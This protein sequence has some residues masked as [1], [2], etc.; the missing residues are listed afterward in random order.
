LAKALDNTS[1]PTAAVKAVRQLKLKRLERTLTEAR[2]IASRR[3][4]TRGLKA[5][6]EVVSLEE[7]FETAMKMFVVGA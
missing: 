1:D 4:G 3:S 5:R 6:K 7:Q 2:M